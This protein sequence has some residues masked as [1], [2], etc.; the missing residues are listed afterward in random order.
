[1][2]ET[3]APEVIVKTVKS[4][5]EYRVKVNGKSIHM[6][7]DPE[8][9]A[10]WLS[11]KTANLGGYVISRFGGELTPASIRKFFTENWSVS[12]S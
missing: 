4:G 5:T 1:M 10:V 3:V 8:N 2:T 6:I 9:T 12:K 7:Y 11:T